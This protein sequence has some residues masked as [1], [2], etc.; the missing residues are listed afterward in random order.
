[1]ID[2]P[3]LQGEWP[4]PQTPAEYGSAAE[5]LPARAVAM[6]DNGW[7]WRTRDG[8]L[9][10]IPHDVARALHLQGDACAGLCTR[11]GDAR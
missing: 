4:T 9:W 11:E 8:H 6:I 3:I 10:V 7:L 5:N 2:F 1:M